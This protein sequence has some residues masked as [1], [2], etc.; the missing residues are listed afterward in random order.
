VTQRA[1]PIIVFN[2]DPVTKRKLLSQ[3]LKINA[4]SE[5]SLDLREIVDWGYYEGRLSTTIQKMVT[6]PAFL[7]GVDNPVK[8]VKHPEWILRRKREQD[9]KHK[10]QDI[11]SMF[12]T[13]GGR[14]G[15]KTAADMLDIEDLGAKI[16][17]ADDGEGEEE[18]EGEEGEEDV[19]A[20]KDKEKPKK[21]GA[22]KRKRFDMTSWAGR[23]KKRAR[24]EEE[25]NEAEL[26]AEKKE[27]GPAPDMEEDH[28]A[29]LAWQKAKWGLQKK[30]RKR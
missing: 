22:D 10:Q 27:L 4:N 5:T 1:I 21:R 18:G 3:W 28:Q 7:Q 30:E 16:F 26:R 12:E 8:R 15:K 9:D 24:E 25:T 2:A 19:E 11:M 29:W 13:M 23:G 6:L 20:G 17:S 14:G